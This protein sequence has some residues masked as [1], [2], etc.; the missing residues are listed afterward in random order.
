MNLHTGKALTGA[1][2]VVGEA[3]CHRWGSRLPTCLWW[4]FFS[5]DLECSYRTGTLRQSVFTITGG[6]KEPTLL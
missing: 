4:W 6:V 5:F 1:P 2:D 3:F